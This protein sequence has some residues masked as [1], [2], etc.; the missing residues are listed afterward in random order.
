MVQIKIIPDSLRNHTFSIGWRDPLAI[1]TI[2]N[3]IINHLIRKKVSQDYMSS[4][5]KYG[6]AISNTLR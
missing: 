6:L 4:A 1:L 2:D 5:L 3:S